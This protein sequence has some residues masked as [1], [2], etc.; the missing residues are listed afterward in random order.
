MIWLASLLYLIFIH[1][2]GK[3]GFTLCPLNNLNLDFCPGCGL[4]NSISHIFQGEIYNSLI[5]HPLG[6]FALVVIIIRIIKITKQ[7]WSHY[8]KHITVNALS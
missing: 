8:G 2:P 6:I 5:A 7:N 1:T 4:G 3:I